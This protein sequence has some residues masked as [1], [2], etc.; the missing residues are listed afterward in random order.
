MTKKQAEL[1]KQDLEKSITLDDYVEDLYISIKDIGSKVFKNCVYLEAEGWLFI[2][3]YEES[4]LVR[5][6]D[7]G[8][9]IIAP[10]SFYT[11]FNY[12]IK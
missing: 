1:L 2:W 3:T 11:T 7:I 9:C 12:E 8:E 10:A 6:K 5:K 4:Y